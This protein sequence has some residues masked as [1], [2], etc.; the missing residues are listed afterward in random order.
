M[1]MNPLKTL[2]I[3]GATGYVG[4]HLLIALLRA[5]YRVVAIVRRRNGQLEQRLAD[6]LLPFAHDGTGQL[7][8][9]EGDVSQPGCGIAD[10][11]LLAL[12]QAK[13]VAFLH[14]AGLT[15]F[16]AHLADD[17]KRHNV[18][19]TQHAFELCEPLGI[20]EFHHLSTAFVAGTSDHIWQESDLNC[21]QGF[22][23]PYEKSKFEAECYLHKIHT[24]VSPKITLYRPSI[25]VGGQA[26]GEGKST[27]TVYT[28]LKTLHFLRECCKRDI[29]SGRRRL[30]AIGVALQ[31]ETTHAPM[32]VSGNP[33]ATVNLVSVHQLVDAVLPQIGHLTATLQTHHIIGQDFNLGETRDQFCAGMAVSGI[34]YVPDDAFDQ[35]PRNAL[36]E[37]FHRATRVYQPYMHAAPK[38]MPG[39][40]TKQVYPINLLT[41]VSE[42]KAQ[43]NGADN[44]TQPDNLGGMSLACLG[45]DSA[46]HY[47]DR[48]IEKDFGFDFLRR[49]RDMDSCIRFSIQGLRSFDQTIRFANESACYTSHD[50][51]VCR[52]EM[53]EETFHQITYNQLDPKQAFFKGLVIIE[54]DKEAGLKF[55][56][57]LSDYLKHVDEHVITE[58]S[59]IK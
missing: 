1:A 12:K 23:N 41:L 20:P 9:V 58:L 37:R 30:A 52:Y 19:G 32:R 54:G 26:V 8:V 29:E 34:E 42:F 5:G 2:L 33:A 7:M 14:S 38:F 10:G 6:L 17:L 50:A 45:V 55:A 31:G 48:L 49:W 18:T 36:E 53:N 11:T 59:G 21:G 44:Q 27:S 16:D 47:F 35:Q 13:P 40:K 15:R 43:I 24:S 22:R 3:T 28:F 25:V 39:Q 46:Q 56:F 4:R 57:F 51:A